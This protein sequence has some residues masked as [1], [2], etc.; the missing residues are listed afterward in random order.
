MVANH[1]PVP[2]LAH[3]SAPARR[4]VGLAHRSHPHCTLRPAGL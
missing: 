4:W 2:V 1:T 3:R